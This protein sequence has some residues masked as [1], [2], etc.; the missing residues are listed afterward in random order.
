MSPERRAVAARDLQQSLA[1]HLSA[2]QEGATLV[3]TD[4][5][6]RPVAELRPLDPT[7]EEA[8]GLL[9]RVGAGGL[10]TRMVH[11]RRPLAPF[12]PVANRG[13]PASDAIH[14]DREDRF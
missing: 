5:Q 3:V 1:A 4:G 10:V 8:E 12:R 9:Y 14:E 13:R 11:E 2:V 6:G 7:R